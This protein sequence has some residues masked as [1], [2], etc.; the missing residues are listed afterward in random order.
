MKITGYS[1]KNSSFTL[2]E[3]LVVIGILA[4]LT[5]AVFLVINPVEYLKQA[6]DTT[7]MSDLD[8]IDK[9]L[10]V[11]ETQGI[12]SFGTALTVYVSIADNAS[13]TCGS[14]GLPPLP[15]GWTYGCVTSANLQK[16]NA[17]GWIPVDFTQSPALSLAALPID[18]VNAT[19]TGNYYTYVTGGSWELTSLF[20]SNKYSS[21]G[22]TDGGVDPAMYEMGSNKTLSPFAHGLV[23]YW[24]FD[25]N[26]NDSSGYQN[27]GSGGDA[28]FITGKVGDAASST[29]AAASIGNPPPLDSLNQ[30]T[31]TAWIKLS[32]APS[33]LYSIAYKASWGPRFYVAWDETLGADMLGTSA[34]VSDTT[35]IVDNNW[36]FVANTFT[37]NSSSGY[38]IY[39]D[40]ILKN[41]AQTSDG[42]AHVLPLSI[43]SGSPGIIDDFR[44]YSRVL[45]DSEIQAIYN[46][47]R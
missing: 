47:T 28:V 17:T 29:S 27:N 45:S 32:V 7:R 41:T 10:A 8:S 21:R 42:Y 20:E 24:K 3:L 37:P 30:F 43:G 9:A 19:S 22:A 35:D 39:I 16:V 33:G 38:K 18:P 12:T 44:I 31:I 15:S 4:I 1:S 34:V 14:L 46:A 13:S 5:A 11:L 40:G 6:R 23:G 2:I 36:H 25:G 26:L